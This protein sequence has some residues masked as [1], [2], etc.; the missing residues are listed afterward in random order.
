MGY[1]SIANVLVAQVN[2]SNQVPAFR[3]QLLLQNTSFILFVIELALAMVKQEIDAVVKNPYFKLPAD[4]IT[5]S[6][7]EEFFLEKIESNLKADAIFFHF[8]IREASGVQ[9]VNDANSDKNTSNTTPLAAKSREDCH[10]QHS[11]RESQGGNVHSQHIQSKNDTANRYSSDNDS[12][13]GS[14]SSD[15]DSD[16]DAVPK[17]HRD[18]RQN[19]AL[20]TTIS[21]C[22]IVYARNKY[23]NLFQMVTDYFF[24]AHNVS[25]RGVEVYHKMGLVVSYKTV[26]QALNANRQ[27][28]LRMLCEKVNVERFFISYDNMNF[29]KKVQ[30]QRIYNKNH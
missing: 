24:F 19:K 1:A 20:I 11:R 15:S 6:T 21:F 26:W 13:E 3:H 23:T 18:C 7:L 8:L 28:V 5:S 17:S 22:I 30:D 25:K 2:I 10:F 16:P 9:K 4:N 12:S 27:V 29:Y 14:D